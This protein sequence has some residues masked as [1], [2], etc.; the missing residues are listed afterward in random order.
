MNNNGGSGV[1]QL[2]DRYNLVRCSD[3]ISKMSVDPAAIRSE[4]GKSTQSHRVAYKQLR[5]SDQTGRDSTPSIAD[6]SRRSQY[7]YRNRPL[8]P[9]PRCGKRVFTNRPTDSV[10][11]CRTGGYPPNL[12]PRHAQITRVDARGNPRRNPGSVD[13]TA[14]HTHVGRS[15]SGCV[16]QRAAAA[17]IFSFMTLYLIRHASASQRVAT[18]PDD[19]QRPLDETGIGQANDLAERLGDVGLESLYSSSALRCMQTLSPLATT[20]GLEVQPHAAL[21]EGQSA[22]AAVSLLQQL[23]TNKTTAALCSHGDIIPDAIQTL[24]RQGMVLQGPRGWAKGST[25]RLETR[26]LDIT[27]AIY[28]GPY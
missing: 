19:L 12:D 11:L 22:T 7:R 5:G 10:R 16:A 3:T 14:H 27:S 20:T 28:D 8:L 26:G 25:W 6:V 23:A 9:R 2:R 24:A 18:N 21:L 17:T 13:D 1:E 4:L 15:R